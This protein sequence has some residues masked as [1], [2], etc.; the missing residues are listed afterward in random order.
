MAGGE[1]ALSPE[2]IKS[3]F[4]CFRQLGEEEEVIVR[5]S[6]VLSFS[7]ILPTLSKPIIVEHL[8]PLFKSLA[9]N[10]LF[11]A[12][13]TAASM[14]TYVYRYAPAEMR[15]E[16]RQCIVALSQDETPMV[17]RVIAQILPQLCQ[18]I[19]EI[20]RGLPY[21]DHLSAYELLKGTVI[22][23][24]QQLSL[25]ERDY[26]RDL[27]PIAVTGLIPHLSL[28]DYQ[29]FL[30]PTIKGLADD[31]S[32]RVRQYVCQ[33]CPVLIAQLLRRATY[34]YQ[35]EANLIYPKN[36]ADKLAY[37]NAITQP[38]GKYELNRYISNIFS[39][40]KQ[41]LLHDANL[42]V[43]AVGVLLIPDMFYLANGIVPDS[44]FMGSPRQPLFT[45]EA[46]ELDSL[47]LELQFPSVEPPGMKKKYVRPA[48]TNTIFN[49]DHKSF[50]DTIGSGFY[51]LAREVSSLS[52]VDL[53]EVFA[54]IAQFA[55]FDYVN[56]YILP[57]ITILAQDDHVQ[58]RSTVILC[59]EPIL[60]VCPES[61][62]VSQIWPI[63]DALASD[64]R[65][66]VRRA[67]ATQ[68]TPLCHYLKENTPFLQTSV[69]PMIEGL[70]TEN[71]HAVR[72]RTAVEF[73]SLIFI[74][75]L[76]TIGKHFLHL[77]RELFNP[78]AN[79]LHRITALHFLYFSAT[80]HK[81][82][83]SPKYILENFSPFF[84]EALQ[85][86]VPNVRILAVRYL[87][88]LLQ[89][90]P[91]IWDKDYVNKHFLPHFQYMANDSGNDRE[92]I[93]Q[94]ELALKAVGS[95]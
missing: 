9:T 26:L 49:W 57:V 68:I 7:K 34:Q 91:G 61:I 18:E 14:V 27:A 11:G 55:G 88:D 65:W 22:P 47:S 29:T 23:I 72:N 76:D 73:R 35:V 42:E 71:V 30:F 62:I 5:Q 93:Y 45:A 67:V 77:C 2:H 87:V 69:L 89:T 24:L 44:L 52:K 43:R 20:A 12:R 48:P 17:R 56:R 31:L 94:G 37:Q 46:T 63:L 39:I 90:V 19:T 74:L 82:A 33:Q 85:D 6:V 13:H 8:I 25:D 36:A 15:E 21:E 86:Q 70:L 54:S 84:I 38:G 83:C 16:I 41:L 79:Y 64:L 4:T 95:K 81:K 51:E 53:C 28:A 66:R 10:D 40:Y 78:K 59:L 50:T 58:V 92:V 3:F 1:P 32:W 80:A 60:A 75:G